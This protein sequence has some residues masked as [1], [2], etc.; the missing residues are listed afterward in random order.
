MTDNEVLEYF[1]KWKVIP[2]KRI[3]EKYKE[4]LLNRFIDTN[5]YSDSI[6]ELVLS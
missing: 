1:S 6:N 5:I 4:Y 3:E 2:W